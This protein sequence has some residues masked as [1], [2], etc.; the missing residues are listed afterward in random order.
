MFLGWIMIADKFPVIETD[1]LVLRQITKDDGEDIFKYLSDEKVMKY[2]GL[3][4]FKS[5]GEALEEIE[6]YQS[7]FDEDSGIRWGITLKG[8]RKVIGSCGFLNK[9]PQHYRSEIGFELSKDF[10]GQGIANE[11]LEAVITYGFEQLNLQRIQALIE[12][13]NILSRKL[14]ERNGFIKEGLLRNYEFTCGKFDDLFMYSLIKQD[15]KN[16]LLS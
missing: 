16:N 8:N 9:V 1:R 4:P 10:W 7:T 13:P 6:W 3:E 15:F 5:I 11:A 12:P 14:V 2:Y